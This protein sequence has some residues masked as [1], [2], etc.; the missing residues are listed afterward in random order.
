MKYLQ[1][2]AQGLHG[3]RRGHGHDRDL[4]ARSADGLPPRGRRQ[5]WL[6]GSSP[7]AGDL[8]DRRA[9][10]HPR[11]PRDRALPTTSISPVADI[12]ALRSK[13][14]LDKDR[15]PSAP[16]P[17]ELE[18]PA[19]PPLCAPRRPRR[20][21]SRH[22][23]RWTRARSA[24]ARALGH[25]RGKRRAVTGARG[26]RRKRIAELQG[27]LESR[28]R[29]YT[30]VHPAIVDL[31]SAIQAA[32][33]E[34]PPAS[35]LRG[36]LRELEG[37]F[38][39]LGG[40]AKAADPDAVPTPRIGSGGTWSSTGAARHK[41]S[42]DVIRIEQGSAEERDPEIE[43]ARSKL[44]SSITAYQALED[45]IQRARI[46]LDTAEAAFK[47]RY[48]VVAPPEVP[49]GLDVPERPARLDRGGGRRVARRI[50][51]ARS[52]WICAAASSRS[53]GRS[54]SSSRSRCSDL[55]EASQAPRGLRSDRDGRRP[56]HA[57]PARARAAAPARGVA[58]RGSSRPPQPLRS[59]STATW[60]SPRCPS[61]ASSCSIRCGSSRCACP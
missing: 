53:P 3:R 12:Q 26:I 49:R 38:S 59:R 45:K 10:L 25:D 14:S 18:T 37:E 28:R 41:L 24:G 50:A 4:L 48:T 29:P 56:I 1:K 23:S 16:K 15:P 52:R 47:Y 55:V 57:E 32:S 58:R 60:C 9:G 42:G 35:K 13:K 5:A 34:S 22:P 46:D 21:S 11:G 40:A 33:K 36:D 6:F 20:R 61:W 7:R 27:E 44:K 2:A 17:A 31:K 54:N 39:T 8:D 19:Q 43:Y 51:S 30:E